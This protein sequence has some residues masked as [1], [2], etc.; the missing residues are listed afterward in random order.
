MGPYQKLIFGS[1]SAAISKLN[2]LQSI[3]QKAAID[4][5]LVQDI[6][7]AI[8]EKFIFISTLASATCYLN[9][10]IGGIVN[11]LENRQFYVQLLEEIVMLATVKGIAISA[12]SVLR[13][14]EKLQKSPQESTSSMHRDWLS[15]QST[16][17]QSLISYVVE[18]GT[19]YEVATP[20]Y[21]RV[22]EK[23]IAK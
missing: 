13:S 3:F 5:H 18:Q 11:N 19:H 12:D 9:T 22:L 4:S 7:A 2:L 6:E 10:S 1:S 16:E 15:G 21:S 8:W 14:I 23:L 20:M 17:V